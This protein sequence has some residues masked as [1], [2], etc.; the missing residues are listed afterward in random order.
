MNP[1]ASSP[2]IAIARRITAHSVTVDILSHL[3]ERGA[4]VCGRAEHTLP[5]AGIDR[6]SRAAGLGQRSRHCVAG[7]IFASAALLIIADCLTH[8][9]LS[10]LCFDTL[11]FRDIKPGY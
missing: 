5:G 11:F 3:T 10:G 8:R 6:R 7:L 1:G 2:A 4:G 9:D